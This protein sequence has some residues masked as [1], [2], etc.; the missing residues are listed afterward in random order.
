M[1]AT[2]QELGLP[3][4]SDQHCAAMIGLRLIEIPP[5]LFP[6]CSIDGELYAST[7]RRIFHEFDT[8]GAVVL[9]PNVVETLSA[10]KKKG[11]ILTIA[12]SRESLVDADWL[13]DDF[14]Q[15]LDSI[16]AELLTEENTRGN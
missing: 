7:Y 1:Q 2:I 14:S 9:Y 5:V 11:I 4:S 12:S 16:S 13:I 6:E 15:L 8:E 3:R 10:L